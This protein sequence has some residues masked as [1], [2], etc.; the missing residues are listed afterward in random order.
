MS[1]QQKIWDY[2]QSNSITT[3]EEII[4]VLNIDKKAVVTYVSALYKCNYLMFCIGLKR[5]KANNIFKLVKNTGT[6]APLLNK[7]ILKDFNIKEEIQIAKEI[8]V[9]NNFNSQ[10]NLKDILDSF[11]AV[12]KEE[13]LL[14]EVSKIFISKK[15]LTTQFGNSFLKRWIKKL[16]LNKTIAFTGNTYRNSKIYLIDLEKI[17]Q[18]RKQLDTVIDYNLILK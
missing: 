13:I 3:K 7:G 10:I 17:K 9:S 4:N 2:L 6:K 8:K 5:A 18:I 16:E 11:I 1:Q 15:K 12:N 14:S